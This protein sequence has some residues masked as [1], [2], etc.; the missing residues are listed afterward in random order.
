MKTLDAGMPNAAPG[1]LVQGAALQITDLSPVLH[2]VT[3]KDHHIKLQKMLGKRDV[4]STLF[5]F[6]RQLSYGQFGQSAQ[7]EGAAGDQVDGRYVSEVVPMAYYSVVTQATLAA[8]YVSTV[9]GVKADTRQAENAAKV[10]TGD[11]E[12]DSF[13]GQADFSNAGVFDGNSALVAQGMPGM[14]G[15]DQQVRSSDNN[16]KT[17]DLMFAAYGSNTSVVLPVNGSLTQSLIDDGAVRSAMNMG[18]ASDLILDPISLA[19]YNKIAHNKERIVLAGA[20]QEASGAALRTQ[21]TTSGSMNLQASRFLSGK[22]RPNQTNFGAP[23][24]PT[25]VVADA[26]AAASLLDAGAYVYYVTA[27]SIRG[28]SVPSLASTVTVSAAGDKVT[29]TITAVAGAQYY[30]VYRSNVGGTAATAKF[31]GKIAQQVGNPVFVDL[32]NKSPGFVTGYLIQPDALEFGELAPLSKVKLA[33]SSLATPEATYRFVSL[34]AY[35]PRTCAIFDN[36]TG[37]LSYNS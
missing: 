19:A 7:L 36:I 28:E 20:P 35:Q 3:F 2:N 6:D 32:G 8:N 1:E 13:R 22:T 24:A 27:V 30:N 29:V 9:D 17:Q 23:A 11:I 5:R 25:I 34:A 33:M 21:W 14:I 26:G 10:V 4:K 12:F 16:A 18:S 31:I 37:Q 15:V